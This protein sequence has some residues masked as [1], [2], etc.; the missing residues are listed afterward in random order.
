MKA[1]FLYYVMLFSLVNIL[2]Y[3]ASHPRRQFSLQT[4]VCT[5]VILS[6]VLQN[7]VSLHMPSLSC[8][9]FQ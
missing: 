4:A 6:H 9:L 8:V 7:S 2:H 3:M 5:Y 1:T